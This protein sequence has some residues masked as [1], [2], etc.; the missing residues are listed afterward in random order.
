[1]KKILAK[2]CKI[3]SIDVVK[4]VDGKIVLDMVFN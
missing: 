1:M 4:K 3:A 2:T